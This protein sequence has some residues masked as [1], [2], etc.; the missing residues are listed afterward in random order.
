[1][2]EFQFQ[3]VTPEGEVIKEDCT[4]A[5]LPGEAGELGILPNHAPLIAGL[6]IG[7]IRYTKNNLKKFMAVSGGFVKVEDNKLVVLAETAEL[8]ELINLGRA[9]AAK[10]RAEQLLAGSGAD[11]DIR[12]AEMALA[13]ALARISAAEANKNDNRL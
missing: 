11:L 5:V 2:A 12:R 8:G 13:R 3:V 6:K 10:E 7:V 4:F 9:L 1:M